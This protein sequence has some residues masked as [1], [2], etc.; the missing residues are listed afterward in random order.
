MPIIDSLEDDVMVATTIIIKLISC[1]IK[2][3]PLLC[4]VHFYTIFV[5]IQN[6]NLYTRFLLM[7]NR[8][9]HTDENEDMAGNSRQ[10]NV[11]LLRLFKPMLLERKEYN[12][13][14]RERIAEKNLL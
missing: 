6:S 10:F 1:P 3:S 9:L 7:C 14:Y 13:I 2:S 5:F 11:N 8:K 12:K 4:G